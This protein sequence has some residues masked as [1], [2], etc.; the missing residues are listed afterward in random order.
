MDQLVERIDRC[1][2]KVVR[3]VVDTGLQVFI[4]FVKEI[5]R[6]ATLTVIT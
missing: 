4:A 1:C 5:L 3:Q 6:C 2:V